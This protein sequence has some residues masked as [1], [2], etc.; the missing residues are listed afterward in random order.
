MR[1]LCLLILLLNLLAFAYQ[2]WII[3]PDESVPASFMSQEVPELMIVPRNIQAQEE[4]A[5]VVKSDEPAE[6]LAK[7]PAYRCMRI[8][9][10]RQEADANAARAVLQKREAAVRQ[11][12]VDGRVWVGYWVQTQPYSSRGSAEIA[13]KAII[14]GVMPDVYILSDS[15]NRISLGVFRLR[16][17]ADKIVDKARKIGVET[18]VVERYQPGKNYWL[19]VRMPAD[20][21]LKPGDLPAVAGQILR[22]ENVECSTAGI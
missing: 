19:L 15:E 18:R 7:G 5:A 12:A 3:E 1:N 17:S 9:S 2:S 16:S 13:Q 8:G 11:T 6:S 10:F 21:L 20:Q 14:A 22:T 4:P